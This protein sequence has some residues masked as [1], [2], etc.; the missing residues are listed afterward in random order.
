[1]I[2]PQ[3]TVKIKQKKAQQMQILGINR[4]DN[5]ADGQMESCKNITSDRFPYIATADQ[6]ELINTGVPVGFNAVSIYPAEKLFVVSDVP[7]MDG[8]YKCYY[9]G[10]YVGDVNN[11]DLPKQYAMVSGRLIVWPDKVAFNLFDVEIS[12]EQLQT[13][14][15]LVKVTQGSIRHNRRTTS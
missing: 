15:L 4:T 2:Y 7:A 5:Y 10:K 6:M 11:L 13:A 14:P 9:G 12:S 3:N 8:G 1:M